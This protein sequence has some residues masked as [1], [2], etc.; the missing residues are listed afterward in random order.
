MEA[1][2][3]SIAYATLFRVSRAGRLLSGRNFQGGAAPW[4]YAIYTCHAGGVFPIGRVWDSG[5]QDP[6]TGAI[7]DVEIGIDLSIGWYFFVGAATGASN[8]QFMIRSECLPD[9]GVESDFNGISAGSP[10]HRIGYS[11]P[12]APS[13]PY[14]ATFPT[15]PTKISYAAALHF[16][17]L[18]AKWGPTPEDD[19]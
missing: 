17:T 5:S 16:P 15:N 12:H 18:F 6:P 9:L 1:R 14:P 2:T 10:S 19:E 13:N 11:F 4:R 7:F 8:T 3:A